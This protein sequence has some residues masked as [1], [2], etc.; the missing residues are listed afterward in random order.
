MAQ[1]FNP[2]L[3]RN[4]EGRGPTHGM[5]CNDSWIPAKAG[6]TISWD[7]LLPPIVNSY[8]SEG[9][10]NRFPGSEYEE[11]AWL[12]VCH[13][14]TGC[15]YQQS[16]SLVEFRPRNSQVS[17]NLVQRS[18]TQVS[19]TV[20]GNGSPSPVCGV[21]P[22]LVGTSS[23]AVKDTPQSLQFPAQFPIGHAATIKVPPVHFCKVKAGGK[24]SPFSLQS[25]III[26]AT[27][28]SSSRV[29][30]GVCPHALQPCNAGTSA[31]Y[32]QPWSSSGS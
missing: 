25:S 11:I 31:R 21:Q 12:T 30:S 26:L 15:L 3:S 14:F 8:A 20:P 22:D 23:L 29:S 1:T 13:H 16:L 10:A 6:M 4:P 9:I 7:S 19:V 28:C 5:L 18:G 17:P 2:A 24:G 27:S 32:I